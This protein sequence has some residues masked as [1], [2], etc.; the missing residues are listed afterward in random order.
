MHFWYMR[1]GKGPCWG[2]ICSPHTSTFLTFT[3][4]FMRP[5]RRK[6]DAVS[7]EHSRD[8]WCRP[9][10]P[11]LWSGLRPCSLAGAGAVTDGA[12]PAP[13]ML[14]WTRSPCAPKH[15]PQELNT[16]DFTA[17]YSFCGFE[18]FPNHG[19][20]GGLRGPFT[21]ASATAE[22]RRRKALRR[23]AALQQNLSAPWM[24]G[25]V[26]VSRSHV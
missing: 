20:A 14:Q 1:C 4:L 2:S 3:T 19:Y 13:L 25:G 18:Y 16:R 7:R 11:A 23:T 17:L 5:C 24:C 21:A 6:D 15:A 22:R 10:N 26:P 9:G 8:F 12:K